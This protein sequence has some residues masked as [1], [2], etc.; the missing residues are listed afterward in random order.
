MAN[1]FVQSILGGWL[2]RYKGRNSRFAIS[3]PP[4][5]VTRLALLSTILFAK[6]LDQ[7]FPIRC[8]D[9]PLCKSPEAFVP[10]SRVHGI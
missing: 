3:R 6:P 7:W 10:P 8:D 9:F 4:I 2:T 1:T 5:A